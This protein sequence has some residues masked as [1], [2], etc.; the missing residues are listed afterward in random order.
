MPKQKIKTVVNKQLK[1][2]VK[3][4]T[5]SIMVFCS[6]FL[7]S[8]K[9]A[10]IPPTPGAISGA[11]NLCPGETGIVYSIAPVEGANYY[12]WTVPENSKIVSGQGT[13]SIVINFSKNSGKICVRAC[14]DKE[15]SSPSC[16]DVTQGGVSGQWCREIDF[17]PG[18]R[19]DAV[20]FSIGG[21]GY[22]GTG[23]NSTNKIFNDFWEF[24]PELNSWSQ[25]AT[26][27]DSARLDAV[28]FSIGNKGY[29]GTGWNTNNYFSDFWE[30]NTQNNQWTKKADFPGGKRCYAFGLSIL[31]KG[32]IGAGRRDDFS[33][34]TDFWEYN[35]QTDIWTQKTAV[36]SRGAAVAFAIATKGYI[37]LGLD[38]IAKKDFWE[39]DPATDMWTPKTD[40]PG[41]PRFA[42]AGFSIGNKGYVGLGFD[43][44]VNYTDFYEYDPLLNQWDQKAD[45]A[46]ALRA[47]VVSFS[48]GKNGY[49]GIGGYL[50]NGGL[51]YNDFWVYGQ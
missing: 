46:G 13:T 2:I 10:I 4:G 15:V 48:I 28:G 1:F 16:F 29:I 12:L 49:V 14:N 34:P 36:I 8:C 44:T 20:G 31:D 43:N 35:P 19:A 11:A 5:L 27:P 45:F 51:Q 22:L 38:G 50:N 30:Y 47:Y 33:N 37:G 42:T 21:K 7:G 23:A 40:F 25:K 3:T 9:K 17:T 39:Y 24:D 6:L 18:V 32:Y 41:T 26:F